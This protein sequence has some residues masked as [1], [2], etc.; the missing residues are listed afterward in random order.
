M[1]NKIMLPFLKKL[2]LATLFLFVFL[3]GCQKE[4]INPAATSL[5]E[6]L[7]AYA[8]P[9]GAKL[10]MHQPE[11][12]AVPGALDERDN[13]WGMQKLPKYPYYDGNC[14]LIMRLF[15]FD[16]N[17]IHGGGGAPC[18]GDV[19]I[20]GYSQ[21]NSQGTLLFT[22]SKPVINGWIVF[23]IPQ[24]AYIQFQIVQVMHQEPPSGLE[25]PCTFKVVFGEFGWNRPVLEWW[26]VPY[27]YWLPVV[28]G[29]F[30]PKD[31]TTYSEFYEEYL[32]APWCT[33]TA[34]IS[35]TTTDPWPT[36]W[37]TTRL[38]FFHG[39]AL[40]YIYQWDPRVIKDH[41][42]YEKIDQ[43]VYVY[44]IEPLG[45]NLYSSKA[46]NLGND[47]DIISYWVYGE[48]GTGPGPFSWGVAG[49]FQVR[50]GCNV[51]LTNHE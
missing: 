47:L 43:S 21:P 7:Q 35:F 8:Q 51:R 17:V 20:K 31:P 25:G 48:D 4:K 2:S 9:N 16:P 28:M 18:S 6:R 32:C 5:E 45:A 13:N 10:V 1:G 30:A 26:N 29:R 19:V 15:K 3:S 11:E 23:T 24:S 40:P 49:D 42:V 41:F 50:P 37:T 22:Q 46:T 36:P 38:T 27:D 12:A 33:W 14:R 34:P 39:P 44:P